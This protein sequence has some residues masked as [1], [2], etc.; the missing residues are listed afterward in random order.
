MRARG[1]SK[2]NPLPKPVKGCAYCRPIRHEPGISG[3]S[4]IPGKAS[5]GMAVAVDTGVEVGLGVAV[6]S[7]VG[8][9]VGDLV[10]V[11]SGV[12]VGVGVTVG[13]TASSGGIGISP[14]S[15]S[16][17]P[18]K[19]C[20]STGSRYRGSVGGVSTVAP[21]FCWSLSSC[22]PSRFSNW[23]VPRKHSTSTVAVVGS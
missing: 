19:S 23:H 21:L 14:L 10:E 9:G 1:A 17:S 12:V 3:I 13:K 6:G 18:W 8:S 20:T 11:G 22:V 4:G 2:S 7:G 16:G 15:A 5:R